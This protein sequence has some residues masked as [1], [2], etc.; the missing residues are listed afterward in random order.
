MKRI[1]NEPKSEL[2]AAWKRQ[3]QQQQLNSQL[4]TIQILIHTLPHSACGI[5]WR[6]FLWIAL[7]YYCVRATSTRQINDQNWLGYVCVCV[8]TH[9]HFTAFDKVYRHLM[10]LSVSKQSATYSFPRNGSAYVQY[11]DTFSA[12][13]VLRSSFFLSADFGYCSISIRFDT[14]LCELNI[15]IVSIQSRCVCVCARA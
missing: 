14:V 15:I 6:S 3:Q 13:L 8:C 7:V 9:A 4:L 11:L 10:Y 1:R 2:D 5:N 12:V